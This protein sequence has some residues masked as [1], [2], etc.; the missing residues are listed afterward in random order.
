MG[1][2]HPPL[3]GSTEAGGSCLRSWGGETDSLALK[4]NNCLL[5]DGELDAKSLAIMKGGSFC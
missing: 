3:V 5:F 1:A 2:R 4:L